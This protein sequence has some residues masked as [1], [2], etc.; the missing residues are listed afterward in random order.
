MKNYKTLT[1]AVVAAITILLTACGGSD[2]EQEQANSVVDLK[3]AKK[4]LYFYGAS[5]NDHYAFF[6][7]TGE[8]ENLNDDF[9]IAMKS[10]E[11]GKLFVWV[12]DED[13]ALM[14]KSDYDFSSD[15]NA[16]WEDFYYLDHLGSDD[17]R[18]PHLNSDF[19]P[20]RE[21]AQPNDRPAQAMI[22]LNEY[23]KAQE[24]LKQKLA[25]VN[26]SQ[27]SPILALEDICNFYTAL[28]EHDAEDEKWHYV[29]GKNGV[30]YAYEEK[31]ETITFESSTPVLDSCEVGKSGLSLASEGILVYGNSRIYLVDSHGG[32]IHV[33]SNWG[34]DEILG[35]GKSI[36]M[37]V[38]IGELEHEDD[39]AH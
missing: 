20:N 30:I 17:T 10:G 7:Q 29:L 31:D 32:D 4:V 12:D 36:D 26:N 34:I 27:N 18:H 8:V 19:D 11:V 35:D 14:L 28:H 15:A 2:S 22:R 37:M 39:H 33:H 5:S 13:K 38:G 6:T 16:T 3:S 9:K 21:G 25:D 23:I 24:E 1:A